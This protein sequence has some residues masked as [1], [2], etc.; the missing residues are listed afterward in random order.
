MLRITAHL[1]KKIP[2]DG[3][4]FSSQQ[5]SAGIETEIACNADDKTIRETLKRLYGTLEQAIDE[6][7][8]R[9]GSEKHASKPMPAFVQ[10]SSQSAPRNGFRG[11]GRRFQPAQGRNGNGNGRSVGATPAQQKAI[12]A[13]CHDLGIDLADALSAYG[14]TQPGELTVRQASELID[15]LKAQQAHGA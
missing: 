11:Q 4:E 9:A 8:G 12:K 7:I 10:K 5:F 6:Q 1:S 3:V 15:A 14:V 13:L 2:L